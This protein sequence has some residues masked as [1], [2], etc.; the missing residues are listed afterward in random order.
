M[1]I[2]KIIWLK[3]RLVMGLIFLWAFADKLFGLGYATS[4]DKSWLNGGSPTA[5]YLTN[6]TRGPFVE[7]FQSLAGMP[8]VDWLFML[9]LLGVGLTLIFNKFVSYGAIA[10]SIM[11]ALMYLSA[12][13]PSNNPLIDE[14][15][16]YI[17]VLSA[18][19]IRSREG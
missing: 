6:A 19:A 7:F 1:N 16:V 17:L 5:G 15:I 11:M 4:S 12:F 2:K 9:G 10:G 14:H 18:L 8:L 13:P 3:L